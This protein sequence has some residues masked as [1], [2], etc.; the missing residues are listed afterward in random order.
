[1]TD[2]EKLKN[3][4]DE[5][6]YPYFTDEYLQSRVEEIGAVEGVTLGT[7]AKELCLIKAG[8]EEIK[9]GDVTI[10]SPRKHFLQL[11]SSFRNNMTGTVV[12]ADER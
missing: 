3:M 7:I 10:P 11:A 2:L 12:R 8:I 4:I 5:A 6:Q 9:L 1:M